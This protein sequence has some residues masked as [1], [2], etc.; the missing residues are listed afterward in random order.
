MVASLFTSMFL[1]ILAF[2][3]IPKY[4]SPYLFTFSVA[5]VG[6][7][8]GY[9]AWLRVKAFIAQYS[10]KK[11]QDPSISSMVVMTV[12][13]LSLFLA[14]Q[15]NKLTTQ[16]V[17]CDSYTVI[18]KY[19][20]K[21]GSRKPEVNTLVVDLHF[22]HETIVCDFDLWA[23]KQIGDKISLC[24]F[25]SGLGFDYTELNESIRE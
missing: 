7:V 2:Q 1:A 8:L 4:N 19:R 5:G 10:I 9:W 17:G 15:T 13:G 14:N 23:Q 3:D 12:I 25:E 20:D 11:Y 16:K 18:D 22:K 21:G 24:F 6:S